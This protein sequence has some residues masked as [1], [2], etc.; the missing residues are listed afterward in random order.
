VRETDSN[1]IGILVVDDDEVLLRMLERALCAEGYEVHC[2]QDG[3]QAIDL[4]REH[5]PALVLLDL[6]MARHDGYEFLRMR[7]EDPMLRDTPVVVL[8]AYGGEAQVVR[9]IDEG[10]DDFLV[11]PISLVELAARLRARF[12]DR[13]AID[14]LR[15]QRRDQDL[16]L[17]LSTALASQLDVQEILFTVASRLGEMIQVERVSFVILSRDLEHGYVLAASE[18]PE[19][20]NIRVP[21]RSYPEILEVARTRKPLLVSDVAAHPLLA[22]VRDA[23]TRTETQSLMLFPLVV[24]DEVLGVLFLR[25][26]TRRQGLSRREEQVCRIVAN[27]TAAAL[28]NAQVVQTIRG[29]TERINLARIE[30]ERK[31]RALRRYQEFCESSSDGMATVDASGRVQ[32][33]NRA[34]EQILGR[35]RA[36]VVGRTLADLFVA[37]DRGV[38][39]AWMAEIA[40]GLPLHPADVRVEGPG[41]GS[42]TLCVTGSALVGE[43]AAAVLSFRDVTEERVAAS[44][45]RKRKEFL[46]GLVRESADAIVAA[47]NRGRI[48]LWNDAAERLFGWGRADAMSGLPFA[49]LFPPG[50]LGDLLRLIQAGE[51]GGAGRLSHVHREIVTRDGARVPVRLSAAILSDGAQDL[52][53]FCTFSDL[54][55]EEDLQKRLERAQERLEDVAERQALVSELAG[56]TAHELNQ[57][58]TAILGLA[59][60]L[61]RG[62]EPD[63][64]L[65]SSLEGLIREAERIA[66]VVRKLG[67]ITRYETRNYVGATRILDLERSSDD[68]QGRTT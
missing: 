30:A 20:H 14:D 39:D 45:L 6:M 19:A 65:L 26:H 24:G 56:T 43:E 16:L 12:R 64:P 53:L 42:R 2:A 41:G 3:K 27:A 57:P 11:K 7:R 33:V 18:D 55:P 29:E 23:I 38:A 34:G 40:R 10:A 4:A 22:A 15:G 44:D 58:L 37:A 17:D 50:A 52:A 9:A 51:Q 62:L 35:S 54:R 1:R 25:T 36:E 28:R 47:D 60:K 63:H 48:L 66:E 49:A 68:G 5:R 31:V 59:E 13:Q 32:F 67:R 61:R 21:L 46:E 8:T